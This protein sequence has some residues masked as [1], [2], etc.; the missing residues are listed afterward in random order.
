MKNLIKDKIA[1][2][3]DNIIIRLVKE[4]LTP[5]NLTEDDI[6][7]LGFLVLTAGNDALIDSIGLGTMTLLQHLNQLSDFKKNPRLATKVV[8]EITRYHTVS[9]LNSRRAMKQ[10]VDIGGQHLEKGAG[11]ICSVQ[12]A[13]RDEEKFNNPQAFNIHRD[14][15]N[16]D[17]LGLGHGPHRCQAEAFSLAQLKLS[18]QSYFSDSRDYD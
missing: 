13:N 16:A 15:S 18:L 11:V 2:Q 5:G 1:Q 10:E 12:A 8:N 9:A 14:V 4:Q 6:T 3:G 7:T 17:S